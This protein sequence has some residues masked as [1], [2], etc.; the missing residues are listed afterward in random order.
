MWAQAVSFTSLPSQHS[1]L[2]SARL[3]T[4][5]PPSLSGNSHLLATCTARLF[6]SLSEERA[7][8]SA[9]EELWGLE[10]DRGRNGQQLHQ[11]PGDH[12]E[13]T[14]RHRATCLLIPKNPSPPSVFGGPW[15]PPHDR[16][17]SWGMKDH[18]RSR[19]GLLEG[20]CPL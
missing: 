17:S 14:H 6:P 7:P 8:P 2:H 16:N 10:C 4:S 5:H 1:L 9:F 19:D 20:T 12:M 3:F 11:V 13:S 18:P 15:N